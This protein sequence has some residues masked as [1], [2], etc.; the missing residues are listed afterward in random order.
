M[1]ASP[2]LSVPEPPTNPRDLEDWI[3]EQ[4]QAL[5]IIIERELRRII[6]SSIE[7][8][9]EGIPPESLEALTAAADF[10]RFDDIPPQWLTAVA[11]QVAPELQ[12]LYLSGGVSV[13]VTAPGF[14]AMGPPTTDG[15]VAVVNQGAVAYAT[16]RVPLL[17]DIGY[18]IRSQVRA[19]VAAAVESGLSPQNLATQIREL[20]GISE[21]R[22]MTIARTEA[23]GAYSNGEWQG[24]NALD[25]EFRPVEKF[26]MARIDEVT[27]ESH[28]AMDGRVVRWDEPYPFASGSMMHPHD[29]SGPAEEIINCRC[30][31]GKLFLG[32]R[33]PDGSRAGIDPLY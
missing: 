22:A 30:S 29:Y 2:S 6:S 24:L 14:E 4:A 10:S 11:N 15:W 5:G 16:E 17:S 23:N 3:E 27:R 32:M 31:Q 19:K 12:R 21:S 20:T 13:T 26:W 7:G 33:R 1:D 28:I 9:I 8:F 25:E 18:E